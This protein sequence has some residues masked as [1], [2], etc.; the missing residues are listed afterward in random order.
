MVSVANTAPAAKPQGTPVLLRKT[1]LFGSGRAYPGRTTDRAAGRC[2]NHAEPGC[3]CRRSRLRSTTSGD[4]AEAH[5]SRALRALRSSTAGPY[6]RDVRGRLQV[7]A[8]GTFEGLSAWEWFGSAS[9]AAAGTGICG[10]MRG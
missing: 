3:C 9:Q 2:S 8:D 4:S 10:F 5:G 1:L 7:D 6:P